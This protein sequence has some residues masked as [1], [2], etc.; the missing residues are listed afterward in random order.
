[1]NAITLE[2]QGSSSLDLSMTSDP[3]LTLGLERSTGTNNYAAL[4]NKPQIEGRTLIGNST[5]QQIGV[6]ALPVSEIEK[7]LYL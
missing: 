3:T 2:I 1:M 4:S 5:I 6:D 7:I